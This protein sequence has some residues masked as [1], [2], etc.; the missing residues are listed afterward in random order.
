MWIGCGAVIMSGIKIGNG[1]IIGAGA[2]VTHDVDDYE[3]VGGVPAKHIR[4]RFSEEVRKR[5]NN[6]QWWE[7]S[8]KTIKNNIQLFNFNND[9]EHDNSI[10]Q[11]LERIKNEDNSS[12][13]C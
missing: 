9:I 7:F 4:Y 13:T 2:V 1:A 11:E 12:Y 6:I 5:L 3:I 10:L 8:D